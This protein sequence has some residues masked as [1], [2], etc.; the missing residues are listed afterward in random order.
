MCCVLAVSCVLCAVCCVLCAVCC[1]LCAVRCVVCAVRCV[2][3]EYYPNSNPHLKRRKDVDS[4]FIYNYSDDEN[5]YGNLFVAAT[6]SS[7]V[8]H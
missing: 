1:V 8:A 7:P 4:V 2:L 5:D 3:C 6:L